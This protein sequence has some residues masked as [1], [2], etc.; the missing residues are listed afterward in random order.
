MPVTVQTLSSAEPRTTYRTYGGMTMAARAADLGFKHGGEV[1]AVFF[2]WGDRV[3]AGTVLAR[4]RPASFDAA[5]NSADA[6]V[7]VAAASLKA[8]EAD[9]DIATKTERRFADLKTKSHVS[10]HQHDEVISILRARTAAH[11]VAIAAV[12]RANAQAESARITRD[13]SS[14]T[15]PFNGIIQA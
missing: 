5:V 2:D 15:A 10:T 13:E 12:K 6:D 3:T 9:L 4:L 7:A 11:G 1:Q 14:I 8:A